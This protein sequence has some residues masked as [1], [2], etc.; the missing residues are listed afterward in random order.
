M[1]LAGAD[2]DMS[3]VPVVNQTGGHPNHPHQSEMQHDLDADDAD[4]DL[5]VQVWHE[6]I[7]TPGIDPASGR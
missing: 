3:S 1:E 5:D 6:V 2:D 4:D 7:A